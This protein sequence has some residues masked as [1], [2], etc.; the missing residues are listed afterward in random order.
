VG[1]K[2]VELKRNHLPKVLS[3][4]ERLFDHNDVSKKF[5]VQ[6][7]E[8]EV[9]DCN[10]KLDL[11]LNIVKLSKSLSRKQKGKYVRLMKEFYDVF[12]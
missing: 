3:P 9:V 6:S 7:Q 10:I 1:H 8:T 11:N 2:I 12:Y 4:L 5:V